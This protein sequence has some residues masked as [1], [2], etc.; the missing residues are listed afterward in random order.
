MDK[1]NHIQVFGLPRSGTNFIEYTIQFNLV[2]VEYEKL[3]DYPNVKGDNMNKKNKQSVKHLYPT[4]EYSDYAIII[5]RDYVEWD[6]AVKRIGW[7]LDISFDEYLKYIN[8]GYC[9]PED[10][11]VIVNHRWVVE[12]YSE[13]LDMLVDKF[14]V[15]VKEDW[16]QPKKRFKFNGGRV[17]SDTDYKGPK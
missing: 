3:F 12:N 10:K 1:K 7:D 2:G 13:F 9:L 11:R 6:S 15:V 16:E 14:G 5:Y 17:W 8:I 4:L